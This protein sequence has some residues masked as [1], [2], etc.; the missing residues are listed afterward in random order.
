MRF[1]E[2]ADA[3]EKLETTSSRLT[4]VALV[5]A[6]LERASESE[7]E[8][9]VYLLQAQ[10]RP[11]YE[12]IDFGLGEKLLVETLTE[13]YGAAGAAVTRQYKQR[14]DL[15]LVAEALRPAARASGPT[16]RAVYDALLEIAQASGSGSTARKTSLL[17]ALLRKLGGVEAKVAVRIVQ[18]R[19]RLGVGDQTILEAASLG[20][21][22]YRR[23]KA[24]LESAYN[25]RS[26]L[27][28]VVAIAFAKGAK[29]LEAIKPV[30]GVPVRPALAQRLASAAAII[31]R[32]G[33]VQVE[34]K[35]DGFRL[36]IHRD[37]RRAWAFSR[38]L[39][40]VTELFPEL[41]AAAVRE[42]TVTRA[43]IEGEAIG[44]DPK[45]GEFLPFQETMTYKRKSRSAD[46]ET[47]TPL[48]L[49]AFDLMVAGRVSYLERPQHERSSRLREVLR[50]GPKDVIAATESVMISKADELSRYFDKMIGQGLEGVMAKR[51][52]APYRA[53]A[54][55][56]DWVKLK[57]A[58]QSSLRDTVDLVIV[59]YLKGRGKRAAFGI[60]SLLAAVYVPKEDRF[61][62]VAK[63]GAGLSDAAWKSLR[64]QLDASATKTKPS[65]IDSL[66]TPDVWVEPK[67][68]LEV[69]ADEISRSPR[70]A[71]G[72]VGD[73]PGYALR[74]PRV[75]GPR[76]DKA[77]SDATTE[78]EILDMFKL[79]RESARRGGRTRSASVKRRS[80]SGGG[81]P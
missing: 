44:Y 6:L 17:A 65:N 42:L 48:H 52:D 47:R 73:E 74:F 76:T 20:A 33:T 72:K 13:A 62:T 63:I 79:Q 50:S 53:G 9:I 60:G 14:G 8:P 51:P 31:K 39:E 75:V 80:S 40:N 46:G 77:P 22:G 58:Y 36:Q 11:P 45:T 38:R 1:R 64:T 27:G 35:Y 61:R 34:P 56:Y 30:V 21:L 49:F 70:H 37:G 55:S 24:L 69:L 10:L 66:I 28:G 78:Q 57:R 54:R 67:I 5:A 32:L 68:V 12:G 71:T 2:F 7:R 18:G 19:L 59:G 3:C 43:I 16:V 29:G 41:V 4:M 23:H 15:G 25:V 81:R 26:D